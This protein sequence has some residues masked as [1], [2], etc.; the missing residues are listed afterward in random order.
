MRGRINVEGPGVLALMVLAWMG[1]MTA[2]L[3]LIRVVLVSPALDHACEIG[4]WGC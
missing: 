1:L 4:L 2:A 3:W